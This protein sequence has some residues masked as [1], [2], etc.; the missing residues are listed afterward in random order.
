MKSVIVKQSF[1]RTGQ[2]ILE[3]IPAGR[4]YRT[5]REAL[6]ALHRIPD[7]H[8]LRV[9]SLRSSEAHAWAETRRRQ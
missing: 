5:K 8:D 9:M 6:A 3:P 4:H 2:Q 1:T 7:H